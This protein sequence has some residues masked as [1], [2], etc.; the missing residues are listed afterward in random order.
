MVHFWHKNNS[1]C[2]IWAWYLHVTSIGI[3]F[4]QKPHLS[5]SFQ[6]RTRWILGGRFPL[7]KLSEISVLLTKRRDRPA[8]A[9]HHQLALTILSISI[10]SLWCNREAVLCRGEKNQLSLAKRQISC[11][12]PV[13][14]RGYRG[15][16]WGVGKSCASSLCLWE[17]RQLMPACFAWTKQFFQN[18]FW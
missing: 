17:S 14:K 9:S 5:S 11:S 10:S 2:T 16:F 15:I 8:A 3:H 7:M 18:N 4:S 6:S 1:F 12:H 13:Y